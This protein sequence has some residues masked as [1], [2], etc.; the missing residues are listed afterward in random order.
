MKL[1]T[2][3]RF[4]IFTRKIIS[5]ETPSLPQTSPWFIEKVVWRTHTPM[6][7]LNPVK[8]SDFDCERSL[9]NCPLLTRARNPLSPFSKWSSGDGAPSIISYHCSIAKLLQ[10]RLCNQLSAKGGRAL[11]LKRLKIGVCLARDAPTSH[12]GPRPWGEG[13]L[14]LISSPA[15]P[16]SK[17]DFTFLFFF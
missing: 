13:L 2:C 15:V 8:S 10:G 16:A 3:Q 6:N 11:S 14:S 12:W 5:Q 1:R 17:N 9:M 7:I 4:L